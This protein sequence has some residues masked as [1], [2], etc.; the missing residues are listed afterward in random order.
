LSE[1]ITMAEA[2]VLVHGAWHGA[3]CWAAVINQLERLG[4]RAYAVDLPG[5]GVNYADRSKVTLD[6]YVN[7]VV[8][9][10]EQRNL[11]NVVLAGHSL[12]GITIPGVAVKIPGRIKRVIWVTAVVPLQGKPIIDPNDPRNHAMVDP[13]AARPDRS[14]PIEAMGDNFFKRLV[15]DMPPALVDYVKSALCPQPLGPA[16]GTVAMDAYFATGIPSSYIVCEKDETPIDGGVQWHP[17]FSSRLPNPT[18]RFINCGH[19]V[20]FTAPAE[21]ARALHE[22]AAG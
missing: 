13:A 7:S 20:M 16:T 11:T 4:D 19:E 8:E 15:N 5:H 2:F 12:G 21:C 17:H 9:L 1:T 22:L 6:S 10:I 14:T 18:L 3:W